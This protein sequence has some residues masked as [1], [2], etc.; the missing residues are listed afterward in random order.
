MDLAKALLETWGAPGLLLAIALVTIAWLQRRL[1]E[2]QEARIREALQRSKEANELTERYGQRLTD[3]TVAAR[4][5][6][7]VVNAALTRLNK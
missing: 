4:E 3:Q 1:L 7:A 2:S 5:L 6:T